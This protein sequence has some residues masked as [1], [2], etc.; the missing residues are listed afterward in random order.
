MLGRAPPPAT[1]VHLRKTALAHAALQT[2]RAALDLR[3]RRAL[4]LADGQ[5]SVAELAQLLGGD[6]AGLIAQLHASGYLEPAAAAEPPPRPAA[7]TP[8]PTAAAPTTRAAPTPR[9][10]MAAAR[11]YLLGMLE[12]QR[13][14]RAGALR[15]RLQSAQDDDAIVAA[16]Q[17]GLEALPAMTSDGYAARVRAHTLEVLPQPWLTHFD[18]STPA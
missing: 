4:I 10:S 16:L 1:P 12:L 8:A 18:S 14:E 6:G 7:A 5:R 13:D 2:H 3:Q 17:A 11:M 9:R 15:Q